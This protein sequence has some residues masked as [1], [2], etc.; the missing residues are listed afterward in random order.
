MH[1]CWQQ[2]QQ[3]TDPIPGVAGATERKRTQ[4]ELDTRGLREADCLE[5]MSLAG[6]NLIKLHQKEKSH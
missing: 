1:F 5:T 4:E 6:I 2:W 3:D